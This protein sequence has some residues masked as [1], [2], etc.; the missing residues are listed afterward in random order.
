[1]LLEVHRWLSIGGRGG[2]QRV[3]A[4]IAHCHLKATTSAF[5]S[6]DLICTDITQVAVFLTL[7]APAYLSVSKDQGGISAPPM[8]LG[9]GLG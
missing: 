7:F 2:P 3:V 9:F 6:K 8:Y 1:M 4:S 5:R